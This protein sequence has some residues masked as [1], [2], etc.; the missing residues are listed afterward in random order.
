MGKFI[1][2]PYDVGT[3]V[4]VIFEGKVTPVPIDFY[5]INNDGVN[6]YDSTGLIL[7]EDSMIFLTKEDA[8]AYARK[9]GLY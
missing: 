2:L 3:I 1:K 8:D 6:A 7:N 4:Y 5:I 9:V